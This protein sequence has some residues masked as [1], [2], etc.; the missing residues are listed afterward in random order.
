MRSFATENVGQMRP[1]RLA[2]AQ[3]SRDREFNCHKERDRG[4]GLPYEGFI[5]I[6]VKII[7]SH[8]YHQR[9]L[10]KWTERKR[11]I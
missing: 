11:F 6:M 3:G 1:L 4:E 5:G 7:T 10:Y 9:L 2:G 8:I